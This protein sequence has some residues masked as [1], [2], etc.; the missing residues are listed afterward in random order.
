MAKPV[1]K[2][3]NP[4]QA[5]VRSESFSGLLLVITA[6]IAFA[7]ANSSWG[8][9]YQAMKQLPVGFAIGDFGLEKPLLLWV[10]DLLMAIFF[11]FVGLEIKRELSVGEL[12]NPRARNLPI[13]AALGGMLVPALFYF[14]LNSSGPGSA[15]WGVPMATDI[16]FALGIMAL[17]GDRVPL[18]LKVFLTAVAIVD[19]LGAVLVIAVFYTANVDVDALL[20]SFAVWAGAFVYRAFGGRS[21][22]VFLGIGLVMWY[23]MLKSGVHATVAGVLLAF[24]IPMSREIEPG[25]IPKYLNELL[26][27]SV[28]DRQEAQLVELDRMVD[29]AQSPLH[30]LEHSLVPWVAYAIMPIFALFNAGFVLEEGAS[31]AAPVS[32]GAFLGLVLGKPLG[33]TL[34]AFAAVA[35][36]LAALPRA[37]NWRCVIGTGF[38]SGIGFTMSLF[39]AA[40]AFGPDSSLDDQAKLG[41]LTASIVAAVVGLGI[42]AWALPK[43]T[44]PEKTQP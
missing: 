41:V 18:A 33:V 29:K 38:L 21:I 43:R 6:V 12:S 1:Q 16:A 5:F 2:I 3:L 44:L 17:L 7:W 19:D 31:L 34:C 22:P 40:L 11:L 39:I 23:F 36:G 8:D 25:E 4:F 15:G 27:R 13:A 10:N 30:E 42:L 35:A 28:G 24:A 9:A 20:L 26:Q 14:A 37:V 32:L